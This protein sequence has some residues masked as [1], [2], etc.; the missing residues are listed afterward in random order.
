LYSWYAKEYYGIDPANG[1]MLWVGTDGKPTH[2]Y[3]AARRIEYG[4]PLAKIQGGFGTELTYKGF[5]LR[6]SFSYAAG[7]KIYNYFRR[8]VDHDL[9]DVGFNVIMPGSKSKIWQQPGDIA[10]HPLPQNAINSYD[11]STRFIEDG[12]YLKVRNVTLS[13]QL[14]AAALSRL[15]LA[16]LT[17][18]L[19]ADN[20]YTF[21]NFWGQDPEVSINPNNGLPGYAEFKYPN[22]RQ[23]VCTIDF[24]F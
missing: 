17:I 22:N 15:R 6:A 18:S 5:S 19:G 2:D 10:D 9:Q 7:N 1:S 24:R 23:Y 3:Q 16:G 21:T 12:S 13:Y 11:P 20:V 8:Y 4:S 14:S